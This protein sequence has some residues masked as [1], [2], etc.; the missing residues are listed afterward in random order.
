[1]QKNIVYFHY[2]LPDFKVTAGFIQSNYLHGSILNKALQS[3]KKIRK[4]IKKPV[5]VSP[6]KAVHS[7]SNPVDL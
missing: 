1:M 6:K 3:E 4:Q 2:Y 5:N 7:L